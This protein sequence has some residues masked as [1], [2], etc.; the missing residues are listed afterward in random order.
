M[1]LHSLQL[2]KSP[3]AQRVNLPA[4]S[5][6]VNVASYDFVSLG[7]TFDTF[8]PRVITAISDGAL[9]KFN[10]QNPNLRC[11][12]R[13]GYRKGLKN[14]MVSGCFRKMGG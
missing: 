6:K 14:P 4:S 9:A 1:L 12:E 7:V 2:V 10:E 3:K 8:G 5:V 11:W 13:K